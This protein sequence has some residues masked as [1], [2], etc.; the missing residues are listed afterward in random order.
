MV[1]DCGNLTMMVT[2]PKATLASIDITSCT[3]NCEAR[4]DPW[5]NNRYQSLDELYS[6]QRAFVEEGMDTSVEFNLLRTVFV[7]SPACLFFEAVGQL[8]DFNIT[9]RKPTNYR[10]R[11]TI[12]VA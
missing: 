7:G 12:W 2:P 9:N 3:E 10:W 4:L 1:A 6:D 5:R 8:D 11:A